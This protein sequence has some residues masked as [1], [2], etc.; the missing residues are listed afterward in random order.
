MTK[1]ILLDIEGTT[2]PLDFVQN[3][4][5]PYAKARVSGYVEDNFDQ[6]RIEIAELAA[7]SESDPEYTAGFRANSSNSVAEYLKFLIDNDRKS[8]P[9]KSIQGNIWQIGY[10]SGEL[11]SSVFDDVPAA[12]ERWKADGRIIAIYSSGSVL[13]QMLLFKYTDHGDLTEFIDRYFDTNVGHK[14][15][16]ESYKKIA[17][18]LGL[19]PDQILFVSD[20]VAELDAAREAGMQT[21]M[22]VRKGNAEIAENQ[23]H[24]VVHDFNELELIRNTDDSVSH[25]PD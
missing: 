5:F 4:L 10:E 15:E 21:A 16:A 11:H 14:R 17:T 2:T 22:S 20:V 25:S 13:A 23:S 18:E 1:A 6:L 19:R 8:T 7:E 12:F 9:L 24:W 3:T